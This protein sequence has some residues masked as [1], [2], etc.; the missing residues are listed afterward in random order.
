VGEKEN[1]V[2]KAILD[3][4]SLIKITAWQNNTQGV[5]RGKGR[6]SFNPRCRAGVADILGILPD[7]RFL[8]IECKA[9]NKYK[10][11]EDGLSEKQKEFRYDIITNNGMYLV[12]DDVSQVAERI[13]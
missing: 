6:Y 1:A 7:G 3:Y 11:P 2:V 9:P 4:L 13:K 10:N 8:A 5:Y 12:V